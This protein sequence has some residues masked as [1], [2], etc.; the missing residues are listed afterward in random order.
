MKKLLEI[1]KNK[2]LIKGTTTLLLVAIV[3]VCFIGLNI[4]VQ[5]I[6][7]EDLDFTEKKLYSLSDE[8]KDKI[9]DLDKEVTIQLIN[10]NDY[11]YIKE[12]ARKYSA[13]TDKIKVEEIDDL[14]SRVDLKTAYDLDDSDSLIVVKTEDAEK[15]LTLYD[16]YTIDYSTY[17]QIDTTEEAITNA[18]VELTIE[19]KPLI[20]ILSTS[21][22]YSAQ[23]S[24][25]TIITQLEEDSNEV[26][27]LDILTQGEVPEDCDCLIITTLA[28]DITELERDKIIEYIQRG[29]KIM[30]LTSQ[31]VLE[32][33]ETP[34][35][36]AVLAE[37]GISINFG[38][39]FE[40]DP[41]KMLQNAPEFAIS[42]ARASFMNNIDMTLQMCFIDAGKIE[43]ADDERLE[44]LGVTYETIASTGEKSFI[45]TDFDQTSYTRT[46]KDGEEGSFIVGAFVTKSISDDI[47]SE[48]IIYSSEVSATDMQ[49]PISSQYYSYAIDLYNNKDIILNSISY[50]TERTDTITIRKTDDTQPYSVTEQQ[51]TII[52]III[53][54][55]PFVI[56]FIGIIVWY[57]RKR[58]R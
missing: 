45:R 10:M 30:I 14:S 53:F 16:L 46:S 11:G 43:F 37:Y 9:K 56:I 32:G 29:G 36:D 34:N 41:N 54:T 12:F 48:L 21:T 26:E 5:N 58:R 35:Y 51:D 20:Y 15:T 27:Y 52:R 8:T 33:V 2:W 47:N 4:L 57:I 7:V 1:I 50:L 25:N 38:V 3:L 22:Y 13:L 18:I 39:I 40:Q 17:E 31:N 24:L 23:Q 55:I 6:N 49:I 28:K 19:R 42:D 44:E